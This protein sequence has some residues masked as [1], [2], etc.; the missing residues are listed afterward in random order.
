M[1]VVT[2][3]RA[4]YFGS[5]VLLLSSANEDG[6]TNI[7]PFS[8]IWWLGRSCMLG[9]SGRSKTVANLRR[10]GECV[11]NLATEDLVAAIDRLALSSGNDPIPDYKAKMGYIHVADKF[12]Y[13]GLHAMPSELVAPAR[14]EEC[15]VQL[16]AKV[17]RIGDFGEPGSHLVAIEATILRSHI[18]EAILDEGNRFHVDSR[19]WKPLI[20]SFCDYYGLGGNLHDSRL[21]KVF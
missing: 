18:D 14:V 5:P 10:R 20:M 2:E 21:A 9:L 7:A 16:E 11:I 4:F 1:H 13:A 15:A 12:S 6:S 3:P 8:S 19:R 17:D